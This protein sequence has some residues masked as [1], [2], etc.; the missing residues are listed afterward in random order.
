MLYEIGDILCKEFFPEMPTTLID[1][2]PA[3][4]LTGK[5]DEDVLG[6]TYKELDDYLLKVFTPMQKLLPS[7]KK[8]I[9]WLSINE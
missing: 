8:S 2:A 1:K 3:D 5:T 4:G 7:S 6:F 9:E